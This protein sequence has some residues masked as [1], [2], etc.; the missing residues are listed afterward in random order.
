ME[1]QRIAVV[2]GASSGIGEAT[3]RSLAAA[4]FTVICAARRTDR[5]ETLAAEIG[6][7]AVTCDVSSDESV[8]ELASAVGER[9]DVLVNNAGGA[10]GLEPV[11][12]ADLEKWQAMY[13]SNVLGAA[14]VTKALLPA[15]E[16]AQGSIVFVTSVAADGG[17]E[18][19]AGYCGVKAA[20][21]AIVQSMR[22]ELFDRPVRI[23]EVVPG[24]VHTDFSLTRFGGD[25]A[26]AEKVY[27]GVV[28]PLIAEDLAE[29]IRFIAE[30]P[31]HVNIDRMV[32]RP[33]S[34][35]AQH[36]IHRIG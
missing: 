6:G 36:K 13:D 34:Q 33:R 18:G 25:S 9:C 28:E 2:T 10:L 35:P 31:G 21:R 12:E 8:A 11:S 16:A 22:L 29:C 19:G 27:A 17:Y 4:G 30:R 7:R 3:A 26:R 32:V 23:C 24:M 20:E 14:R 1:N 15:V 5:I